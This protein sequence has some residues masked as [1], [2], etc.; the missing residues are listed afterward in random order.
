MSSQLISRPTNDFASHLRV[1]AAL[2]P[3][4]TSPCD[5]ENSLERHISSHDQASDNQR[6]SATTTDDF[7]EV[8]LYF[9]APGPPARTV[10]ANT[11]FCVMPLRLRLSSTLAYEKAPR[12]PYQAVGANRP[13]RR[14][15]G[16]VV[17]GLEPYP[18]LLGGRIQL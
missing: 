6:Q 5:S 2:N 12:D 11:R 10:S 18:T 1:R 9:S 4:V 15:R 8:F 16:G 17:W 13:A 7:Q 3:S 14:E